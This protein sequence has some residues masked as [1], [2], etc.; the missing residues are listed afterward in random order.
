M[1]AHQIAEI[2]PAIHEVI[3]GAPDTCPTLKSKESPTSGYKVPFFAILAFFAA[4]Q[5]PITKSSGQVSPG[6][7]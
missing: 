1:N 4:Y 2:R 3:K 5:H 7:P 6:Q